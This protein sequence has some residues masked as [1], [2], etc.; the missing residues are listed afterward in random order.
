MIKI[1]WNKERLQLFIGMIV[2]TL[3]FITMKLIGIINWFWIWVLCPLWMVPLFIIFLIVLAL[4]A[5][6]FGRRF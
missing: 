4:L 6:R 1:E 5:I 2:L 3:T